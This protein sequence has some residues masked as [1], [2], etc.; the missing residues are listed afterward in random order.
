MGTIILGKVESGI[1]SKGQILTLMPNKVF[2]WKQLWLL[3]ILVWQTLKMQIFTRIR[4]FG[5]K[6]GIYLTVYNNQVSVEV[7]QLF[8]DE[9]ET[10][11][12]YS[13]ENVRIKLKN[14]E[15][16]VCFLLLACG[17]SGKN[18]LI[19]FSVSFLRKHKKFL[20]QISDILSCFNSF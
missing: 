15:E 7:M 3:L 9:F 20:H 8:S 16:E 11:Q 6:S 14:V 13:G 1:I 17:L 2:L 19:H 12:V 4:I 5:G 18:Y 10:E